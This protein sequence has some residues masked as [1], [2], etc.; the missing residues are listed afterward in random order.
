[1]YSCILIPD[2]TNP[3]YDCLQVEEV[4]GITKIE[5]ESFEN[6]GRKNWP[7][8]GQR[9]GYWM[10]TLNRVQADRTVGWKISS[11]TKRAMNE[12]IKG[13]RAVLNI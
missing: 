12:V 3:E 1:M 13:F 10:K 4:A 2:G 8:S 9:G 7:V 5:L 11:P 6:C